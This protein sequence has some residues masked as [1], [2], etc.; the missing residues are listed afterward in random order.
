MTAAIRAQLSA[1][2]ARHGLSASTIRMRSDGTL[3][4]SERTQLVDSAHTLLVD[5]SSEGPAIALSPERLELLELLG[6]G[7]MGQVHLGRQGSLRREVAVKIVKDPSIP[8]ASATL[9]KEAWVGGSLEHPNVVPVHT[10]ARGGRGAAVV[11]KRR[12]HEPR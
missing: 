4:A 12:G 9:L 8:Q 2:W 7:G 1:M 11:M 5:E 3:L 10:L 6:E